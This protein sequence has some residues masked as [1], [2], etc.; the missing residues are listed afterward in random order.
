MAI[1][2]SNPSGGQTLWG[3]LSFGLLVFAPYR[4]PGVVIRHEAVKVR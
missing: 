2:A 1:I 4:L 3:I